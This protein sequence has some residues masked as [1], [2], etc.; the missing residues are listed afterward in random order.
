M[1]K[2]RKIDLA[3]GLVL[4]ALVALLFF[5]PLPFFQSADT[6]L[7]DLGLRARGTPQ[8]PGEIAI[9]AI[10]DP[11][12]AARGRWP[13]PRKT[14]AE[15]ID[16]LSRGGA[17]II[18][19][20]I[21]FLPTEAERASGND[22]LLGRAVERAGNVIFP[23]YFNLGKSAKRAANPE[24]PPEVNSSAFLLF[25][26]PKKMAAFPPPSAE[27]I[28]F[29]LT[30]V[31]HAA[32]STGHINVI[33]DRDGR[34]RSEHLMIEYAGRYY[35][36]FSIQIAMAALGLSAG[37]RRVKAGRAIR[38]GKKEIL[39]NSRG[40]MLISYYGGNGSLPYYSAT[41]VLAGKI[42]ADALRGKLVL[43]GVTAAGAHDFLSTPFSSR[44]P[45]VE[46][47]GQAVAA[48]LQDR[49]IVRPPWAPFFEFGLIL[50]IGLG[51]SFLLPGVRPGYQITVCAALLLALGGLMAGALS[52]GVWIRPFFPGMLV[53]LAYVLTTTRRTPAEEKAIKI[54]RGEITAAKTP[55][56]GEPALSTG[57][58]RID[59]GSPGEKIDRYE[60]WGELGHGAMG[61]VYKG[62]DPL[63]DRPVA[64]KTIRFDRLYGE[65]ET[66][67]LKERFLTEAQA[68]GK[69][70]HP[71]IVTIFDVGEDRGLSY[72][73]MEYVEGEVLS[74][75]AGQGRLLPVA[76]VFRAVSQAAEALDFA[77]Q[78]GIVHRDIKPANIMRTAEGL[79]KVM[80]FGIAK[81]P[82][83]TLTQTGSVLGTP[84]YMS[85]E[86]IRGEEL[87]GRSDL[88]SLGTIL[89]ELLT[90]TKPFKGDS[91]PALTYQITTE[92][93]P[94][95]S[96]LNPRVPSELDEILR[97]ALAKNPDDRYPRGKELSQ[98]LQNVAR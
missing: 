97:R 94:P 87:D 14:V 24:I 47:H 28:F 12:L 73:A 42:T 46:K 48:I 61:V 8:P 54:P 25:D 38:L 74:R 72:I 60:I 84:S 10:D 66:R 59:V 76:E 90:G 30:D 69:L 85:P 77:H 20:D 39:T 75:Y 35:P 49:F 15:L 44:F 36:S 22:R 21:M 43:I 67:G 96:Q 27:E 65:E 5:L 91:L 62:R 68:A 88:F 9:V 41:E 32:R 70:A 13:W 79:V 64:I 55:R 52:Q 92:D 95:A 6:K 63:I 33:P 81:L 78:R 2:K 53:I 86:Q 1:P 4:T 3:L 16:V 26:D 50:L 82:S 58:G 11:S 34:V 93:P 18:A 51:L 57:P 40:E 23:F 71:N 56:I 29:C 31:S 83:S 17:R 98:A 45:G 7:Y 37:D 89:Y 19:V 80:D